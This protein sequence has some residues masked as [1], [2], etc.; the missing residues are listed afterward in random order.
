VEKLINKIREDKNNLVILLDESYLITLNTE[1][2]SYFLE[3]VD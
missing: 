1:D 2:C 3:S